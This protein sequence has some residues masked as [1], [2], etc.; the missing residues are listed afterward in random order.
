[1]G[2]DNAEKFGKKIT[3]SEQFFLW[4]SGGLDNSIQIHFDLMNNEL[5]DG[6]AF[7]LVMKN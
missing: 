5:C 1:M 2:S 6:I 3:Q 7:A 4:K